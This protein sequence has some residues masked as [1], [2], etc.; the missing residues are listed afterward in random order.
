MGETKAEEYRKKFLSVKIEQG[1]EKTV[2][3]NPTEL[4]GCDLN[5]LEI[6]DFNGEIWQVGS[7][8]IG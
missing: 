3:L 5:T 8:E 2:F 7:A 1:A 6:I 4:E